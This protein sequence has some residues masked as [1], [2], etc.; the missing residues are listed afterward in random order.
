MPDHDGLSSSILA[1]WSRYRPSMMAQLQQTDMLQKALEDTTEHFANLMYELVSVRKMEYHQA[2]ELA[3]Q[4]F[5]LPEES[6]STSSRK[7]SAPAT[8]E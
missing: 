6:S 3:M 1:H 4:Q 2:W 8:S 7:K 5:L